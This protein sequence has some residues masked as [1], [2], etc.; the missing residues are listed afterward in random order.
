MEYKYWSIE[1]TNKTNEGKTFSV[2]LV[3]KDCRNQSAYIKW[4]GCTDYNKYDNGYTEDDE[5]SADK[6]ENTDYIHVCYIEEMI[7]RLQEL[8]QIAKEHFDKCDY[9]DYWE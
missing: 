7:Q 3:D 4:D 5:Y 1:K 2:K 8:K 6:E 9:E